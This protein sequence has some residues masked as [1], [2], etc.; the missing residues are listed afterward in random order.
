[1]IALINSMMLDYPI[2]SNILPLFLLAI[3]SYV[4]FKITRKFL[5]RLITSQ[6]KKSKTKL[7]DILIKNHLF[8]R[9]SYLVPLLIIDNFSYILTSNLPVTIS[10][11]DTAVNV[12]TILIFN[13]IIDSIL[14]SFADA[15]SGRYKQ[16]PLKSYMQIFKILIII[17]T[18]LIILSI[19]SG[20]SPWGLIGSIGALGAVLLLI[21]RDTILSLIA[22]LQ[23]TSNKLVQL[24]DWIEAPAF[25]ADGDVIEIAL[26]TIKVQNWDKTITVIPTHKLIDN[27]FKNWRG[28]E[29][30]GGRRI[31]R[32]INI[33][34]TS[35]KLCDDKMISN[36]NKI[37][38]LSSYLKDKKTSLSKSNKNMHKGD[39]FHYLNSRNLTNIG[40]FRA[41]IVAYLRNHENISENM[42]FLV[43]QLTPSE[44]GLPIEIYVFSND[45]EWIN[46]ENI[47]SD[48][49]DHLIA[50]TKYFDLRI[51][52]NPSGHDFKSIVK[53]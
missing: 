35:I 5:I 45:N 8:L 27:S 32:S 42:T 31:K 18:G 36:L 10:T 43:R 26:H 15:Y 19:L 38:L 2:L 17:L 51:F 47:Q 6:I 25:G 24:H 49:F 30:S 52:Q 21:F 9:I 53:G 22:N 48:I 46:Y 13:R 7:D 34:L 50:S 28:M 20:I 40:T 23:I 37:D 16:I 11:I 14:S 12:S 3:A 29:Q 1:M 41:Y 33:D 4:S 39:D 44:N